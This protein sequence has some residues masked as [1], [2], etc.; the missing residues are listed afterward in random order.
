VFLMSEV[1]LWGFVLRVRGLGFRPG[2]RSVRN[3]QPW[4][5]SW[6]CSRLGGR[7][8]FG[9]RV[10]GLGLSRGSRSE[11]AGQIFYM[12]RDFAF[13]VRGL[14]FEVW[15]LGLWVRG[16]WSRVWGLEYRGWG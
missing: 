16:L 10:Q 2:S 14:R 12:V 3:G 5:G 8:G 6:M 15:V 1:T 7:V 9:F 11:I 4:Y 13:G